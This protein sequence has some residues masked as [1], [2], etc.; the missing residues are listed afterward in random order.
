[1]LNGL[2]VK[3]LINLMPSHISD[4]DILLDAFSAVWFGLYD[5]LCHSYGSVL[6]SLLVC[7]VVIL[8]LLISDVHKH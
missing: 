2:K 8:L 4:F 5:V 1:M 6:E 7:H 3:E